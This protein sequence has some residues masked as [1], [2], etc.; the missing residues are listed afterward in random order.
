MLKNTLSEGQKNSFT[1]FISIKFRVELKCIFIQLEM[2][3]GKNVIAANNLDN[4]NAG[5]E[6]FWAYHEFNA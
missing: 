6:C 3:K 4:K 5:I 1:P 2:H